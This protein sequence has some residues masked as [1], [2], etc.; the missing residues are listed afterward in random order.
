MKAEFLGNTKSGKVIS[1]FWLL[2]G[3]EFIKEVRYGEK[4]EIKMYDVY[5]FIESN[6]EHKLIER[7]MECLEV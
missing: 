5:E 1:D 3:H 7:I 4:T 2:D 6:P